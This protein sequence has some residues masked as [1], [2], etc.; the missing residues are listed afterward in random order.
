MGEEEG[1]RVG[2]ERE[3]GRGGGRKGRKRIKN[4]KEGRGEGS[5]RR[6]SRGEQVQ[7]GRHVN[8]STLKTMANGD[9]CGSFSAEILRTG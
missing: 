1:G 5:V 4:G 9:L 2:R 7:R 3:N 6:R 8:I